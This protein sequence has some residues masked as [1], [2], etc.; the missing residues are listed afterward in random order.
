MYA[1]YFYFFFICGFIGLEDYYIYLLDCKINHLYID[2]F[3]IPIRI[4]RIIVTTKSE[5]PTRLAPTH[6]YH[7]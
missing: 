7:L 6:I 1:F 2:V 4:R 3:I 5:Y